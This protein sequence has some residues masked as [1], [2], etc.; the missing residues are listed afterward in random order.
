[1]IC[2]IPNQQVTPTQKSKSTKKT[3]IGAP[4]LKIAAFVNVCILSAAV[5]I[6]TTVLH[7]AANLPNVLKN[8]SRNKSVAVMFM[9][10]SSLL[11]QRHSCTIE[12]EDI[13]QSTTMKTFISGYWFANILC[14]SKSSMFYK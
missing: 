11:L 7:Q 9:L 10:S 3:E 13:L 5:L 6:C 8:V 1:M 12:S 14:F 2:K 4:L